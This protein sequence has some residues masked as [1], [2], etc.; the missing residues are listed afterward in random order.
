VIADTNPV[1]ACVPLRLCWLGHVA[2]RTFNENH[3]HYNWRSGSWEYGDRRTTRQ[4][5]VAPRLDAARWLLGK[6]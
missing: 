1:P 4:H 6:A 5:A 2:E 3:F